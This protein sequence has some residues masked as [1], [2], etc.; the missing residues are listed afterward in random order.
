MK[1]EV[2]GRD[3]PVTDELRA[4]IEKRF[5]KIAKQ[6]SESASLRL[7]LKE[8]PGSHGPVEFVA[9]VALKVKGTTLR[10]TDTSRDLMHAVHQVTDE[11][12]V[13]VK[14]HREKRMGRRASR[15]AASAG[16]TA[17]A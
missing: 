8:A 7:E 2:L 3:V 17:T 4:K 9:D 1:I 12:A 11:L 6:V 15:K 16:R 13:Q 5:A 10:A 14:R